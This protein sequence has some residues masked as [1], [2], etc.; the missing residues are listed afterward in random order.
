MQEYSTEAPSPEGVDHFSFDVIHRSVILM[1]CA[2]CRPEGLCSLRPHEHCGQ[3]CMG[4]PAPKNGAI[5]M[6]KGNGI[7]Q[8]QPGAS[9][10]FRSTAALWSSVPPVV[11]AF[12]LIVVHRGLRRPRR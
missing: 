7:Q 9:N 1:A 4:P 6:T 3:S 10:N 8:F 11:K 12:D 2:F 5:R